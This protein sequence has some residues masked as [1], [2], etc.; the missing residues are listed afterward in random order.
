MAFWRFA[1]ECGNMLEAKILDFFLNS[2][3]NSILRQNSFVTKNFFPL[4]TWHFLAGFEG[5]ESGPSN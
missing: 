1:K 5:Y 2:L 3:T 4:P